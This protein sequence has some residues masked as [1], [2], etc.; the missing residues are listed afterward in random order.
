MNLPSLCSQ[1]LRMALAGAAAAALILPL[2]GGAVAAQALQNTEPTIP[3]EGL[4]PVLLVQGKE[5]QGNEKIFFV[6]GHYKYIFSSQETKAAFEKNPEQYEVGEY[7]QRMGAPVTGNPDLHAEHKGKI[8]IFGS[9]SC[10]KAFKESPDD[11]IEPARPAWAPSAGEI[12]RGRALLDKAMAAMG[13]A[14]AFD[15]LSSFREKRLQKAKFRDGSE[16]DNIT[17]VIREIGRASC[18]ERV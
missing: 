7:C 4:D 18:R 10:I 5:V 17:E 11:F 14:G 13:G 1:F 15:Q 3:I 16:F 2:V 9:D 8:Y 6:R 12:A